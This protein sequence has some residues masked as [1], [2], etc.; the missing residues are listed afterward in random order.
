VDPPTDARRFRTLD[1]Y[2]VDREWERYEGTAQ[3]ALFR[4]LRVRFLSR[5]RAS[6]GWVLDVGSGPG[7]F[8]SHVGGPG[9][10]RVA[11][12]LSVEMLRRAERERGADAELI[13][14][15]GIRP[16]FPPRSFAEVVILGNSL[17]F[18][19]PAAEEMLASAREMVAPGGW[20]LLEIVAG[21]G[22]RARYLARLPPAAAGR[23]LRSPVAAVLGR[24]A[25]E[26]FEP[27][28]VRR[29]GATEFRRFS[30]AEVRDE[31][32]RLGW[33]VDEV[34]AVAPMTGALREAVGVAQDDPKAWAHLLEAE[35][36]MGRQEARWTE[37][38]ALLVAARA[39]LP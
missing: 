26:G 23:L 28:P 16:P 37:A 8:L 14:G 6:T 27:E 20:L 34:S 19:G 2:R 33:S 22:E 21:P 4:Q 38:A 5:H 11:L 36:T 12:D 30:A 39:P 15:D 1:R 13:R 17:G 10:R 3:R 24:V 7:R 32:G 18:A 31:F 35:E 9:V 25:R 29:P